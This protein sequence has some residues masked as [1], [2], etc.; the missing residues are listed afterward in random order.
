M[1]NYKRSGGKTRL[2]V[3]GDMSPEGAD[4]AGMML[5][6]AAMYTGV[7]IGAAALISAVGVILQVII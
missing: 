6:K 5:A 2:R 3:G 7:M 1:S 4:K